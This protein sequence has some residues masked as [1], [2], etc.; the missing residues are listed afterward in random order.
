[1][2]DVIKIQLVP[3][4]SLGALGLDPLIHTKSTDGFS[5]SASNFCKTDENS[6]VNLCH[7]CISISTQS[8][9]KWSK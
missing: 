2:W 3:A 4:G 6:A 5:N 7:Y 9:L 1:M 8:N